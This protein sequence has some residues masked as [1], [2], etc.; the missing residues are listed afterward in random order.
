MKQH[1]LPNG[2]TTDDTD[3]YLAA[4]R[5]ISDPL[6]ALFKPVGFSVGAYDPGFLLFHN[7]GRT[8]LDLDIDTAIHL[9]K[10]SHLVHAVCQSSDDAG[11][12]DDLTVVSRQAVKG[13]TDLLLGGAGQTNI[14]RTLQEWDRII[15]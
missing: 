5:A 15:G 8:S 13:L 1:R 14:V 9:A 2:D 7:R 3:K 6:N 4:W 10:L 11:C 12:S